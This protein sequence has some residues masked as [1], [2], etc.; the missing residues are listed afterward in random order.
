MRKKAFKKTLTH[1]VTKIPVESL[2]DEI[3]AMKSGIVFHL[4]PV[5]SGKSFSQKKLIDHFNST[6]RLRILTIEDPIECHYQNDKCEIEQY[7]FDQDAS[8]LSIGVRIL[9]LARPDVL[10]VAEI[11]D[12]ETMAEI[13][14]AAS[15][16]LVLT[17]F[18]AENAMDLS[19][20]IVDNI[21][22]TLD[23]PNILKVDF[24]EMLN[25]VPFIVVNHS[26]RQI[27]EVVKYSPRV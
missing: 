6:R 5:G 24:I 9:S 18:H 2:F 23:F 20:R 22:T 19:E 1:T 11:Y 13:I 27:V 7:T 12:F 3:G 8:S 25:T 17:A 21:P 26:Q 10:Q 14:M 15:S 4:G 16:T